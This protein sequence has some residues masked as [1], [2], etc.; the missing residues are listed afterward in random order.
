MS[1]PFD[2]LRAT[3][4]SETVRFNDEQS[5]RHETLIGLNAQDTAEM[6]R[7]KKEHSRPLLKKR[8]QLTGRM[9]MARL[10]SSLM[11]R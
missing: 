4:K 5:V 9:V 11:G 8:P 2:E 10:F 6:E 3:L 1:D 7:L